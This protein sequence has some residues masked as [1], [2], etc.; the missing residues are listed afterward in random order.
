MERRTE[1]RKTSAEILPADDTKDTTG[2]HNNECLC[3]NTGEEGK[4]DERPTESFRIEHDRPADDV[5]YS[6]EEET[7]HQSLALA[8][9]REPTHREPWNHYLSG[10]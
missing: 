3:G 9:N 10:G 8:S 1:M 7:G 4:L 2:D 6:E 5:A